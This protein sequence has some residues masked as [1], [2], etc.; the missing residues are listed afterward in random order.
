M[1][2]VLRPRGAGGTARP[3]RV[4]WRD[5]R[6]HAQSI[7]LARLP[8]RVIASIGGYFPNG[9]APT[10]SMV[11]IAAACCNIRS[12]VGGTPPSNSGERCPPPPGSCRLQEVTCPPGAGMMRDSVQVTYAGPCRRAPLGAICH[13]LGTRPVRQPP[14]PRLQRSAHGFPDLLQPVGRVR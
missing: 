12:L 7:E 9:T 1:V 3:W 14:A 8:V 10:L 2:R 13:R 11:I 6:V 4:C 5:E